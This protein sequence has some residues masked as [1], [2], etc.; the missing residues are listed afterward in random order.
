M[1]RSLKPGRPQSLPFSCFLK[2]RKPCGLRLGL[3]GEYWLMELPLICDYLSDG[4]YNYNWF[5]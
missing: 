2:S 4:D 3:W 1:I 5:E